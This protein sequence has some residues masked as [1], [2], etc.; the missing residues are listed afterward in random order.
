[1]EIKVYNFDN[2][3]LLMTFKVRKNCKS[4]I[5]SIRKETE[6]RFN[7]SIRHILPQG[8]IDFASGSSEIHY[9]L[10]GEN[11]PCKTIYYSML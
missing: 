4:I 7:C 6:K 2:N 11:V 8:K 10:W 5:E 3:E 1:M 9:I